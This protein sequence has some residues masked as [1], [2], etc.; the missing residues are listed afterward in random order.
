MHRVFVYGTLKT[1][2][3]NHHWLT[4][5]NNGYSK[6]LG[7]AHTIEKYPLII[8][9]KYNIPFLLYSPGNGDIIKGEVYEVDE[10]MLAN[11]DVLEDHPNYYIRDLYTVNL[12]SNQDANGECW[13][14]FLKT[15]DE[16]LLNKAKFSC[17]SSSGDHG[18][19][20]IDSENI[21]TPADLNQLL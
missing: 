10:A 20:Y 18:L 13:I 1:G 9:T 21:S 17:Y 16:E 15:F 2:E 6:F 7:N 14:Y 3:P 19:P 12:D 4:S 11:L 5:K 8:A